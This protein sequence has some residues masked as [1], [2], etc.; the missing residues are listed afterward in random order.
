MKKK[1]AMLVAYVEPKLLDESKW[2]AHSES[3]SFSEWVAN[4]IEEAL[5]K[6]RV[7]AALAKL[8]RE[9]DAK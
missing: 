8:T 6:K 2:S 4:A 5:S 7:D 3:I 9:R 1:K